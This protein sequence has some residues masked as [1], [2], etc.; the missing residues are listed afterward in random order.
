MLYNTS[1]WISAHFYVASD[2]FARALTFILGFTE[3]LRRNEMVSFYVVYTDT[4]G[5][6]LRLRVRVNNHEQ[7]KFV[8]LLLVQKLGLT[9]RAWT[10]K[11]ETIN[12]GIF[13]RV[14]AVT[15]RPETRRYGGPARIAISEA[16]FIASTAWVS[17]HRGLFEE[18]YPHRLV[19]AG[20]CTMLTLCLALTR[21]EDRTTFLSNGLRWHFMRRIRPVDRKLREAELLKLWTD[22][23]HRWRTA[24]VLAIDAL[25]DDA[26][27]IFIDWRRTAA[28]PANI[29]RSTMSRS[30]RNTLYN[31][32]AGWIHMHNNRLCITLDD[33][34][35]IIYCALKF[36][37][38]D[39][40]R[41][42]RS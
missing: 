8:Q 31:I 16:M 2:R 18:P 23:E 11:G 39:G 14:R 9:H 38:S 33:E 37:S 26:P 10:V 6:H 15:Y 5:Q 34:M 13:S 19:V 32:V 17:R 30:R 42:N 1:K 7:I 41:A 29:L 20:V 24:F 4:I 36:L 21:D 3:S 40:N 35:L 12:D 28:P 25:G 22:D 27:Q